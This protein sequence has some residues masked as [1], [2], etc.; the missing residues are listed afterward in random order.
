MEAAP[1]IISA[2]LNAAYVVGMLRQRIWAWPAGL[3]GCLVGAWVMYQSALYAEV[4]LYLIYSAMAVYGWVMWTRSH[5]QSQ[6][7]T[8][9][10]FASRRPWVVYAAIGLLGTIGIGWLMLKWTDNPRPYVDAAMFSFSVLA[11]LWQVQKRLE[12]WYVWIVIN[13]IGVWLYLDRDMIYYTAY[14]ALLFAMSVRGLREWRL[15][16]ALASK[17]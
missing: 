6:G 2:L 17:L 14:S 5:A 11:T 3:L 10:T 1:E 7:L 12:N 9:H 13:A 15:M 4:L 16:L 8:V